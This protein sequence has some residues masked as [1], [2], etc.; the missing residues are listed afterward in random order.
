MILDLTFAPGFSDSEHVLRKG[1]FGT[2][3]L[4]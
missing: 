1:S 4:F 2:P 3:Y